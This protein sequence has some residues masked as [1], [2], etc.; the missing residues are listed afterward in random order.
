MHDF[1]L[2]LVTIRHWMQARCMNVEE[3]TVYIE[4]EN[5]GD[6]KE[7]ARRFHAAVPAIWGWGRHPDPSKEPHTSFR[8]MGMNFS[9]RGR[10]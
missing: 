8:M 6:A 3:I 4:V 7:I 1:V 10:K 9:I 2:L 5:H